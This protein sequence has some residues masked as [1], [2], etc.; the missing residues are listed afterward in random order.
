MKAII[1]AAGLGT[2]FLPVT[3]V[4]PKEMLPIGAK[5]ALELIVDEARAA[6]ASEVVIVISEGKELI[7]RYFEGQGDI[8][9]V[10]QK[11]QKGLGHAVLQAE[12]DDDVLIL[13]GDALVVGC[14]A[15]KEMVEVSKA[16]GGAAV[17]GCERVP[18]EKVSR[19]GI[20]KLEGDRIVDMV[21]KPAIE[22]APSDIAVA[23]RYLLPAAIFG[24]LK[25]QTPGKGGEIQLTDAIR[26]M[27]SEREAYAYVYPGKRQDI[28]N[29]DG[30]FAALEAY[31]GINQN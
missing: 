15:A 25:T 20:M 30:Y 17:I 31:R 6:G 26:R 2:R 11:E 13:L 7:R 12:I 18:K 9:F 24:Y 28:G 19:Y 8:R 10:Y 5:P 21:E 23:G 1:P 16:H 22:E 27:L 4:V 3:R 14:C 29:P